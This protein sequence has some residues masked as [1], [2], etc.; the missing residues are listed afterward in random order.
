MRFNLKTILLIMCFCLLGNSSY[1]EQIM[2]MVSPANV[3]T[4]NS[5]YGIYQNIPDFISTDI[6]NELN[7]NPQYNV[8]DINSADNMIMSQGFYTEYKKFLKNYKDSGIID[9]KTCNLINEKLGVDK[10]VLVSSSFSTQNMIIKQPL[11]YRLGFIEMEP[12]KSYYKLNV[13]VTLVD[14]QS[15]LVNFEKNYNTEIKADNFEIPTNS[16]NDNIV[17]TAEIQ[18]FS[19][20]IKKDIYGEITANIEPSRIAKVKSNIISIFNTQIDTRDGIT[21]RD[22]HS[23]S[24]NEEYLEN[25]RKESFQNWIREKAF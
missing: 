9:Y 21:T 1:A 11:L 16:F 4:A 15:C 5:A 17:S 10:I 6:I 3:I 13:K 25:K 22:G 20:K 7:K 12:V 19:Q 2:V 24:T 14:T 23:Y 8:P 18:D